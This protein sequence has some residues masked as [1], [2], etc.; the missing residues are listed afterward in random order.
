ML[1]TNYICELKNVC[2]SYKKKVVLQDVNIRLEKGKIYGFIGKNGAGKTT[3]MKII[4]GLSFADRGDIQIF[5]KETK[6]ELECARSNIGC[7]IENPAF[8]PDMSAKENLK[9][10][11]I[12][13]GIRDQGRIDDILA[14]IG[15]E[16]TGKKKVKNFSL[17][18]RQ[19][20]GIGMALL[21]NPE[22]LILDEP[23][24]GLD[25]DGIVEIRQL[26]KKINTEKKTTI[27]ISSHIL[28]EIY[29]MVDHYI[30]ISHGK[31]MEQIS[32]KE[33]EEKCQKYIRIKNSNTEIVKEI[34]KN[35]LQTEHFQIMEDGTCR[36]YDYTEDVMS[37]MEAFKDTGINVNEICVKEDSLE[38]YFF[39]RIG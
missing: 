29:L 38:E 15:L 19:R 31:I 26:I 20:L 9:A 18:M 13:F 36:L 17:G 37:V 22:L 7:M 21:N 32:Q 1:V 24:N 30:M 34:L 23:I 27:L 35:K 33:L 3:T 8:S 28:S 5:G 14:L 25:P 16:N 6:K 39:K 2:K 10:L 11:C 4:A 12:L